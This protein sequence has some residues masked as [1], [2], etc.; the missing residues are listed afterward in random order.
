MGVII[1]SLPPHPNPLPPGERG[2]H[3][4]P[5]QSWGVFWNFFIKCLPKKVGVGHYND[6]SEMRGSRKAIY[7]VLL[8][9]LNDSSPIGRGSG[10][11]ADAF[12][13]LKMFVK[14][15]GDFQFERSHDGEACAVGKTEI[16]VSVSFKNSKSRVLNSRGHC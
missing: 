10:Q 16:L 5:Q 14:G 7:E 12:Q 15:K 8:T 9:R 2:D 11:A 13:L 4:S 1:I 6:G 3:S